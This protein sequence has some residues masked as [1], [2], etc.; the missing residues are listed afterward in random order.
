MKAG[1]I[2]ALLS[3]SCFG[4]AGPIVPLLASAATA[5]GAPSA[6]TAILT[7]GIATAVGVGSSGIWF[8]AAVVTNVGLYYGSA[9][10]GASLAAGAS[11]SQ[12]PCVIGNR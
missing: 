4:E 1:H 5:I 6:A 7:S 12:Q 2:L 9:V 10:V 8:G 11:K 3:F